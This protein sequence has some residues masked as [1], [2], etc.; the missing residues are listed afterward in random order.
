MA[1]LAD[2]TT[3]AANAASPT[4]FA[5]L[6]S[7]APV[8]QLD[9]LC[10]QAEQAYATS[11]DAIWLLSWG[12][13]LWRLDRFQAAAEVLERAQAALSGDVTYQVL[14]G[15]VARRLPNGV[16]LARQAYR[17][18]LL[19]DP[20]RADGY[21][22]LA[23]L[24][25]DDEP[26]LA[27][28]TF[29][30]SLSLDPGAA[31]A[32]HNFG[33][34][35]NAQQRFDESVP[36]LQTSLRLNPLV[37]DAWCNLGLAYF[38]EDRVERAMACFTH[39]ISLDERHGASY[40]NM[41]NALINALEPDQ[42]L[43]YLQRGVEL[44]SSSANSLWNLSL[45]YLLMGD[46]RQ[47]WQYYEARFSTKNFEKLSRP[48]TG[49]Q[50]AELGACPTD[51]SQVPLVVWTEQG[52]GD[53]IQ[54]GRYLTLLKA[55]GV[56]FRFLTRKPLL[57]LFRDWFALGDRVQPQSE[58]T[59]TSDTSPQ[60][61]LLS[62]PYLFQTELETVPNVVPYINPPQPVPEHLRLP[63]PAGGLSVGLVWASNPDNKVM[64]RNKSMPLALLMPRLLDLIDLDLIDL[65]C[66]QFGEDVAQ[67]DPWR[68]HE[69]ITDWSGKLEDFADTAHV[70]RQLDLVISVDTAVAHLG[71]ALNRPTW[72][73]LPANADFR[74]LKDRQDSPW[75]PSMRLFRQPR[76]GDWP[77]LMNA[78]HQAL[79][80]LFLLDLE[81]LAAATLR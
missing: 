69:R 81:A 37:A 58:R 24:L 64:Y 7:S 54:F 42:A 5:Q 30:L 33:I 41:G 38:G 36:A 61:P 21:Y 35:L 56:H 51:P 23:N 34:S 8:E 52:I 18:A 63:L 11:A 12:L 32:W 44:E 59:D 3:L 27:E 9:A 46:F 50:P 31:S 80:A 2:P 70:V 60:I 6:V 57:R 68:S 45:A 40:I 14:R 1:S 26:E 17:S 20:E 39:A 13:A 72:L 55:A 49:P 25:L 77:G 62:L 78:V 29:R 48:T 53:A 15:M 67:L 65:H 16:A 43:S 74:W 19:L 22:N 79:D 28:R 73:L 66:L 10:Q 75:Y 76:H 4:A 71:G 47:G